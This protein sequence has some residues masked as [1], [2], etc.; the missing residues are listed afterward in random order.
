LYKIFDLGQ[1]PQV[2][3]IYRQP[4]LVLTDKALLK[5]RH[6]ANPRA[7]QRLKVM[8]FCLFTYMKDTEQREHCNFCGRHIAADA[9]VT[10][11]IIEKATA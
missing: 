4:C 9:I 11:V 10:V 6:L 8:P 1:K 7:Q 2:K 3:K 5:P